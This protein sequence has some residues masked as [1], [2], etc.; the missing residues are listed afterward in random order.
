VCECVREWVCLIGRE[1]ERERV[2]GKCC[3]EIDILF[4]V[5]EKERETVCVCAIVAEIKGDGI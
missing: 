5:Y 1:R 3:K 2:F 4:S